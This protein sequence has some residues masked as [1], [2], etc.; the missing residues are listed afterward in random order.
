MKKFL[1]FCGVTLL[2]LSYSF[3]QIPDGYYNA[4]I[5]KKGSELRTALFNIIKNHTDITYSGLWSAYPFTD[6][7]TNGKIW[8]IYSQDVIAYLK[9]ISVNST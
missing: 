8:D 9:L 1:A 7:K 5:G 2:V 3:A 4:A 6:V